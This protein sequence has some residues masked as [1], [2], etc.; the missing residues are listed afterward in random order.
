MDEL[1]QKINALLSSPDGMAKIQSAMASLSSSMP[2]PSSDETDSA[3]N[4]SGLLAMLGTNTPADTSPGD[5]T[6]F[7][8]SRLA[9]LLPLLSGMDQEDDNTALLK[10]LRPHLHGEREKRL[11]SA[12]RMMKLWKFLPLL[13]GLGKE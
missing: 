7:D 8:L 12:I 9:S 4:L 1:S 6:G 3:P 2:A 10:A 11:D 5:N 13:S